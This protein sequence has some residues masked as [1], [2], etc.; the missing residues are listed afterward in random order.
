MD[1]R[2]VKEFFK[3]GLKYIVV[4]IIVLFLIIYVVSLE[5]VVGP[6]MNNTLDSDDIVLLNRAIYKYRSIKR[7]E[8]ISFNY[9]DTKYL[10]KRVIGLPN[11]KIEYINNK[12]YVDDKELKEPFLNTTTITNDF[13]VKDLGY[14]KIPDG[15]YLVLGDNRENSLDSRDKKVGLISKKDVVG[16]VSIRLWPL[17]GIKLVK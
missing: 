5:Q 3:D 1:L 12:L 8:V 13:S 14:E 7:F 9:A 17:T 10:V 16:K 15:M 4:I 11:E 6:S 2:D